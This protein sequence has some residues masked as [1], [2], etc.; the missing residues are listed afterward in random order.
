MDLLVTIHAWA[1]REGLMEE[2][3]DDLVDRVVVV[4]PFV[5]LSRSVVKHG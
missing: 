4:D 2:V 5:L 1:V 3:E